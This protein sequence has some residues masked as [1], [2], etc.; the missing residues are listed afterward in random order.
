MRTVALH[1]ERRR[2]RA[3][4]PTAPFVIAR[5]DAARRARPDRHQDRL[6]RRRLRRLH[7]ADRRRAG[8]RLPRRHRAGRRRDDRHGR[9][10][11]PDGLTDRLREAFLAHGA[12]QCGICTPG[13]LMAAVDLPG[14]HAAA[15]SAREVED[16]LGGVLC[17]CTGYVKIVEAVLDVGGMASHRG[18]GRRQIADAR[19]GACA[20]L[21]QPRRRAVGA[22]LAARRRLAKV[23]GT[24]LLRR[25]R[26]A[27]RCAVD[28]RGALAA[29]AGDASR[30][31]ISMRSIARTPG[32]VAILTAEGRAGRELASAS[33][34]S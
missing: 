16:A 14:A 28:A 24:D 2:R 15:P 31:A 11:G 32:L 3:S 6:R 1:A 9:R 18:A 4:R 13:M 34:R 29:C 8:L 26:G 19:R 5:R 20:P 27:R 10:A 12:A 22:R 30:S 23:A 25:R 7:G 17:R 21:T 33:S